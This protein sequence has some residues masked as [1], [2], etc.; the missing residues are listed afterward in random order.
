MIFAW[1]H[2]FGK[3]KLIQ[4]FCRKHTLK[5]ARV[6]LQNAS[7]IYSSIVSLAAAICNAFLKIHYIGLPKTSKFQ[8]P[9][10]LGRISPSDKL[11]FK[12]ALQKNKTLYMLYTIYMKI[13]TRFCFV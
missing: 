5:L 4:R 1:C 7:K 3:H 2:F 6:K 9:K 8:N 11:S 12:L 13:I 10:L